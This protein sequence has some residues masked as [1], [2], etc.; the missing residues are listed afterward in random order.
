M[1]EGG[2]RLV[3][4]ERLVGS[5][6]L[7]TARVLVA[8]QYI[9]HGGTRTYAKALFDFYHRHG[10]RVVAVTSHEA[11]DADMSEYAS[12]RGIE[13]LKFSDFAK[14][15]DLAGGHARPA[16]WSRRRFEEERDAFHAFAARRGISQVT[17]S[18]GTSGLFLSALGWSHQDLLIAHGYPH[19]RRQAL[20]GRFMMAGRMPVGSGL[21][22][23]SKYSLDQFERLWTLSRR[24]VSAGYVYSTCGPEVTTEPLEARTNTVI[25]CALLDPHKQPADWIKVADLIRRKRSCRTAV[26][27]WYGDGPLLEESRKQAWK[28]G[29]GDEVF[30]GWVDDLSKAYRTARV[31]LQTSSTESLG[32]S[33]V[34]ALRHGLP[35]VVTNAGGL[36]EVV[37]D[38]VTG[39]VVPVGDVRSMANAVESLLQDDDLWLRFSRAAAQRYQRLFSPHSWDE[40][41]VRAHLLD[42]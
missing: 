14:E 36:S 35:A 41:L 39:F 15:M 26:F 21:I 16:L 19:G 11:P 5:S 10:A 33:V 23:V 2:A 42:P 31:Y 22:A 18:T 40:A 38:G 28:A 4:S 32:L 34:D 17:I 29:L 7:A 13:L 20:F 12:A 25:S 1:I 9:E 8:L 37:Q 6:K 24:G 3:G 30:P 27:R